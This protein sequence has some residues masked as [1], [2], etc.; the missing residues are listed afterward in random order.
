MA[1]LFQERKDLFG[2]DANSFISNLVNEVG[3]EALF[4][5]PLPQLIPE[6]LFKLLGHP[7]QAS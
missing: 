4:F 5:S 6:E 2:G 1:F 3:S 7:D